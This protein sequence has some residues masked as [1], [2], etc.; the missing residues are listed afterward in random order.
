MRSK[1]RIEFDILESTISTYECEKDGFREARQ[2]VVKAL[3]L[4]KASG[5][6][7]ESSKVWFE[8]MDTG[9]LDSMAYHIRVIDELKKEL[10]IA[11]RNY[12]E[13]LD[14]QDRLARNL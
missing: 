12:E 7:T 9:W 13:V 2:N 4:L 10:E 8:L 6:D 14:E 1:L 3:Q 11:K 5:W